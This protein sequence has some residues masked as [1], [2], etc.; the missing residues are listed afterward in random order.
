VRVKAAGRQPS[1]GSGPGSATAGTLRAQATF[2][3]AQ[4][5]LG[6]GEAGLRMGR[7]LPPPGRAG[8]LAKAT[9][10]LQFREA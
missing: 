8:Q 4:L 5:T 2:R 9:H 3:D 6:G 1:P 10:V 7:D